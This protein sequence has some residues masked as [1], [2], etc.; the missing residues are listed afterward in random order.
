[1]SGTGLSEIVFSQPAFYGSVQS[2]FGS[3]C[4]CIS[5]SL[6]PAI[7]VWGSL[8]FGDFTFSSGRVS[9]L[10]TIKRHNARQMPM[11][12]SQSMNSALEA[13]I[14]ASRTCSFSTL[15]KFVTFGTLRIV[16]NMSDFKSKETG[17]LDELSDF[18]KEC[19]NTAEHMASPKDPPIARRKFRVLITTARSRFAEWAWRATRLGWK[20]KTYSGSFDDQEDGHL[21]ARSC[22]AENK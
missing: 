17:G 2:F 16:A 8:V 3:T 22:S 10:S 4:T 13:S 14:Y 20:V 19:E 9:P 15:D 12:G 18:F 1:M 6:S 21:P 5:I 11:T 7:L